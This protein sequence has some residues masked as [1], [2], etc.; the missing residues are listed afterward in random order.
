MPR[1]LRRHLRLAGLL[2]GIL[3]LLGCSVWTPKPSAWSNATGG[4]QFERL[5]WQSV[6]AK[7]WPDVEARM[8]SGYVAQSANGTQ[9]KTDSVSRLKQLDISDLSLANVDVHPA[10]DSLVVTY[11]L[12]LRGTLAGQPLSLSHA[13]MMTVW[14]QQ[15]RGWVAVAHSGELP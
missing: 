1:M 10:G 15:K 5:W 6:K 4:E 7:D 3:L 2:C 9:T 8:A 11:S 14:Q 12:E 13:P